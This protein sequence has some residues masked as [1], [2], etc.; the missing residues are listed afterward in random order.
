MSSDNQESIE[1]NTTPMEVDADADISEG[2]AVAAATEE[3]AAPAASAAA[4]APASAD[5]EGE[6]EEEQEGEEQEEEEEAEE[7]NGNIGAGSNLE[8]ELFGRE[9]EEA[10]GGKDK[11]PTPSTSSSSSAL[12]PGP[13]SSNVGPSC[14]STSTSSSSAATAATTMATATA[15][16]AAHITSA[17]SSSSSAAQVDAAG[18]SASGPEAQHQLVLADPKGQKTLDPIP[19][20]PLSEVGLQIVARRRACKNSAKV[21][22]PPRD[23]FSEAF[24]EDGRLLKMFVVRGL[25][26]KPNAKS[27]A[28]EDWLIRESFYDDQ[29]E[30]FQ[31][32]YSPGTSC[33]SEQTTETAI[34]VADEIAKDLQIVFHKKP[35]VDELEVKVVQS[36]GDVHELRD[37]L[38]QAVSEL[39]APKKTWEQHGRGKMTPETILALKQQ[40]QVRLRSVVVDCLE[41]IWRSGIGGEILKAAMD[42]VHTLIDSFEGRL[43]DV[44]LAASGRSWH[45]LKKL[46]AEIEQEHPELVP[47]SRKMIV[48]EGR[49]TKALLQKAFEELKGPASTDEILDWISKQDKA[50]LEESRIKINEKESQAQKAKSGTKV[51]HNTVRAV[52]SANFSKSQKR[53]ADGAY[54]WYYKEEGEDARPL[55]LMG[56]KKDDEQEGKE[57]ESAAGAGVPKAK[58]KG[59]GRPPNAEGKSR[60]RKGGKAALNIPDQPDLAADAAPA[61]AAAPADVPAAAAGADVA[62]PAADAEDAGGAKKR[63]RSA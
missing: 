56:D 5:G 45:K 13:P 11:G 57:S 14:T 42:T 19:G 55:A 52:L 61:A 18:V 1:E 60:A 58:A 24:G 21:A 17:S 62:A 48:M 28:V 9:E 38:L 37:I 36:Q 59:R 23:E 7:G 22:P 63:L 10:G 40:R 49:N 27:V 51:W 29:L 31:K 47:L 39:S 16:A 43:D 15:T 32:R 6:E 20:T 12:P 33:T 3:A 46:V 25:H 2:A 8:E 41:G 54:T 30:A 4:A 34:V 44:R 53:R 26:T 35:A 50:V